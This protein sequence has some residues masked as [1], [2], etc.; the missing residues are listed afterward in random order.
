MHVALL[1]T[2]DTGS[3][4]ARA[5]QRLH[6]HFITQGINS[7]FLV[8]QQLDSSSGAVDIRTLLSERQRLQ[9]RASGRLDRLPLAAYRH[10]DRNR[11]WSNNWFPN[12]VVHSVNRLNPDIVHLHWVGT[13]YIPITAFQ[14][15]NTPIVWTLHDSWA[16]T[17]GCHVPQTCTRYRDT[18]GQC[19]LLKSSRQNDLSHL[20]WNQK[21]HN[22]KHLPITFIA[23]S[24]WM[25]ASLQSSSL[26]RDARVEIIPYGVDLNRFRPL[27]R[28]EARRRLG[29]PLSPRYILFS[30]ADPTRDPN[31]G[32][33]LLQM[34]LQDLSRQP[35]SH[36]ELLVL[37]NKPAAPV[38]N[39]GFPVH[40]TGY[41]ESEAMLA[42]YYAAADVCVVPSLQENLPNTIIEAFACG[43]PCVGFQT[44]GIP[45]MIEHDSNGYLAEAFDPHDLARGIWLALNDAERQETWSRRAHEKAMRDYDI[46]TS[47]ERHLKLYESLLH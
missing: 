40:F 36:V 43:T 31:K 4:G 44:S 7:T 47:S 35:H 37:G 14:K 13:G 24:H 6:H 9:L 26:F 10:Y 20:I 19:P 25:A 38:P 34:A 11:H 27:E 22:W 3:G 28:A 42:Q 32:F 41:L 30:G 16:F 29:L 1:N 5:A 33:A 8:R 21:R 2:V 46:A 15:F 23:P 39:L 45:D 17:G 12:D 18:C